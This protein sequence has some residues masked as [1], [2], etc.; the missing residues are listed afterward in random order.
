MYLNQRSEPISPS[1]MP[2]IMSLGET[3]GNL[4]DMI[5]RPY[6]KPWSLVKN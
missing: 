6:T 1:P 3:E 2:P 5:K 4:E